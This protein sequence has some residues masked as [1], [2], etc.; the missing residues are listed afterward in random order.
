MILTFLRLLARHPQMRP[1]LQ[2]PPPGAD[3]L[4]LEKAL[5]KK[6]RGLD[7]A[8]P[9]VRAALDRAIGA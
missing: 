8:N 3:R 2:R 4:A 1:A 5:A 9:R 6:Y 7:P